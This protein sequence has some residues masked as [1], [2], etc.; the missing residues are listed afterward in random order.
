MEVCGTGI[1]FSGEIQQDQI[2]YFETLIATNPC[3]EQPLGPWAVCNLGAMNLAAYV[4]NG[5]FDYKNFGLDVRVALRFLDNVIDQT[6]Y[7]FKENEKSAKEYPPDRFGNNGYR[8][9]LNQ[10]ENP[11][12]IQRIIAGN[13]KNL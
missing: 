13:Q 3:G 6:Y 9:L 1:T 12:R 2:P 11:L 8:R 5:K 7:F 10:N 4:K